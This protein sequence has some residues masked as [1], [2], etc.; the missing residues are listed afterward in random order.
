MQTMNQS[1]LSLI[2][3]GQLSVE[4]AMRHSSDMEE[5]QQMLG[6]SR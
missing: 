2:N 4:D 1:L 3:S 6:A 5:L